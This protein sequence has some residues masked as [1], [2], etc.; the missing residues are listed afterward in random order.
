MNG[1]LDLQV[2]IFISENARI[3]P[4]PKELIV[5]NGSGI[6]FSFNVYGDL[7]NGLEIRVKTDVKNTCPIRSF[8]DVYNIVLQKILQETL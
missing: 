2:V 3:L 5:R 7:L 6:G 1:G 4:L 8:I